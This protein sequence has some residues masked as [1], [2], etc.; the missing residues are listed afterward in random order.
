M[1]MEP[2]SR[3]GRDNPLP[4]SREQGARAL[5]VVDAEKPAPYGE[6]HGEG[7]AAVRDAAPGSIL[8]CVEALLALATR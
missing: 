6:T 3:W 1:P 8:V 5:A 7:V 4:H 2:K